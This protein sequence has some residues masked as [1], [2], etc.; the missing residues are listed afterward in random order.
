MN[1]VLTLNNFSETNRLSVFRQQDD[2]LSNVNLT[3]G[4]IVINYKIW[5]NF[6]QFTHAECKMEQTNQGFK[7]L[8]N[9]SYMQT[10]HQRKTMFY[11]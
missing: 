9:C 8:N 11:N 10:R 5:L 3:A 7:L 4:Y 2:F 6:T 1:V